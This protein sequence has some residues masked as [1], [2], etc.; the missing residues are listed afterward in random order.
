M[1]EKIGQYLVRLDLLSFDQAEEILKIQEEQ[2]NKKFGEIAIELG[3]ITHDDIEYF[4]EKTPS[5]I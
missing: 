1:N 3:Y 4:L 2:P 5:R